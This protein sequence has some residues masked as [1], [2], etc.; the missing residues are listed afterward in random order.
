MIWLGNFCF[1]L[2]RCIPE[3]ELTTLFITLAHILCHNCDDLYTM[4]IMYSH[5]IYTD[6][7][8][9]WFYRAIFIC[10][11]SVSLDNDMQSVK[12]TAMKLFSLYI[13]DD[14][15]LSLKQNCDAEHG[16]ICKIIIIYM[17]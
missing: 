6:S 2:Y 9:N 8:Q 12:H 11:T 10:F 7:P 16:C 3:I 4:W 1:T 5:S 14:I 17:L 13:K 15:S